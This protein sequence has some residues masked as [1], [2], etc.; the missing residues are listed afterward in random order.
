MEQIHTFTDSMRI[1]LRTAH[2][3]CD[4]V[5]N[6]F[7]RVQSTRLDVWWKGSLLRT[8]S[9]ST[10][11]QACCGFIVVPP[12]LFTFRL[13]Q[14]SWK[15]QKPGPQFTSPWQAYPYLNVFPSYS[16]DGR[17]REGRGKSQLTASLAHYSCKI[18]GTHSSRNWYWVVIACSL[19][20]RN[21][22]PIFYR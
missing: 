10:S 19:G 12:G 3:Q 11:S 9:K 6:S 16:V 20:R 21:I 22:L 4:E 5:W 7:H 17:V 14:V 18:W 13:S 1:I 2:R 15:C 8:H